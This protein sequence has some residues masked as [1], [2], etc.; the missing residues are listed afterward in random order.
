MHSKQFPSYKTGKNQSPFDP[1][2]NTKTVK[3]IKNK[4]RK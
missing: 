4:K 3:T 2:N 1:D